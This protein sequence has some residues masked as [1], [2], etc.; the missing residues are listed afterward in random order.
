MVSN[1]RRDVHV[2]HKFEPHPYHDHLRRRLE[3][4]RFSKMFVSI[5]LEMLKEGSVMFKVEFN[6]LWLF[7]KALYNQ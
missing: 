6:I 4:P 3:E 1:P 2:L 5:E 7:M